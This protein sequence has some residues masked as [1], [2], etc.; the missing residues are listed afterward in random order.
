MKQ[1]TAVVLQKPAGL[2]K[3]TYT[4]EAMVDL[5]LQEPTVTHKELGEVFGFSPGWVARVV[6][7]DSFQARIGE[8][9]KQLVDPQIAQSI[10]ERLG[11]IAIQSLEIVSNVLESEQSATYAMEALGLAT[12][13]LSPGG[14]NAK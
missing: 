13:M 2:A 3:L 7:S 5:I 9:K 12:Q 6:A 8:R 10:N 14:G 4:H 1:D 11:G